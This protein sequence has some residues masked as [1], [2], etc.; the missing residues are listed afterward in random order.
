VSQGE[1]IIVQGKTIIY[2]K[3][4][5]YC[6]IREKAGDFLVDREHKARMVQASHFV[7]NH[8]KM[9]RDDREI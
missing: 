9:M 3:W 5:G 4:K 8:K 6:M 1:G 7:K 2:H